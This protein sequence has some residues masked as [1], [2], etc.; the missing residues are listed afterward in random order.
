MNIEV[1]LS[2]ETSVNLHQTTR[3][4]PRRYSVSNDSFND[5]LTT[6]EVMFRRLGNDI[7]MNLNNSLELGTTKVERIQEQDS[8]WYINRT[9]LGGETQ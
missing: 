5:A 3:E 1:V 7:V 9:F 6:T 4:H 8:A 2:S